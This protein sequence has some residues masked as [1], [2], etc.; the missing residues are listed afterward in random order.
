[1][2]QVTADSHYIPVVKGDQGEIVRV[3]SLHCSWKLYKGRV[4]IK[5]AAIFFQAVLLGELLGSSVS[6]VLVFSS[7]VLVF[8]FLLSARYDD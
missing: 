1:M 8:N 4:K 7:S 3:Y 6:T 2:G 5:A